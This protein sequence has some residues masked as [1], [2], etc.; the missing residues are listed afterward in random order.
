MR[1]HEVERERQA[2]APS[3]AEPESTTSA[4]PGHRAALRAVQRRATAA[5]L[6]VP[7]HV[8][9]DLGKDLPHGDGVQVIAQSGQAN[10]AIASMG[11][12]S[13]L[14]TLGPLGAAGP[15]GEY[16]PV[17][18]N[19]W[20]P[21]RVISGGAGWE[22]MSDQLR[23]VGGPR[24]AAGPLGQNSMVGVDW[25]NGGVLPALQPGGSMG[26]SGPAGP[27][28]PLGMLGPLGPTG[29]HG[30]ATDKDGNY[31]GPDGKPV[32]TMSADYDGKSSNTWDLYER[33]TEDAAKK[34]AD[35]DTSF[36]V[37]GTVAKDKETDD[38][39]FHVKTPQIVTVAVTPLGDDNFDVAVRDRGD[40]KVAQTASG[41]EVAWTQFVARPGAYKSQVSLND[42]SKRLRRINPAR[43]PGRY[44]LTVTGTQN[45]PLGAAAADATV[46]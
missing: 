20:N 9:D 46:K 22:G 36:A 17:G 30:H 38:Y 14:G 15:L 39:P 13:P 37:D 19:S 2:A 12:F 45:L 34:M 23:G 10:N 1:E 11:P 28:G 32:R 44:R 8:P 4:V 16:G 24:S 43:D 42:L 7:S 27:L 3:A 33:Y 26:V 40:K 29:V 5:P 41:S 21:S 25:F 18:D 6:P 31:V 35:N